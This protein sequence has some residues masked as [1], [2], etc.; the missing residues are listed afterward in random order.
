MSSRFFFVFKQ[1]FQFRYTFWKSESVRFNS[2]DAP[3]A[4]ARVQ[5]FQRLM[6][7]GI[8]EGTVL[9]FVRL[10]L[11][12]PG[13]LA[14]AFVRLS[15]LP[16]VADGTIIEVRRVVLLFSSTAPFSE[17]VACITFFRRPAHSAFRHDPCARSS[18][19]IQSPVHIV[20]RIVLPPVSI[21][22]PFRE[23]FTGCCSCF[24]CDF[25]VAGWSRVRLYHCWSYL[26]W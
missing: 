23:R 1:Y 3:S 13:P 7:D 16:T 9:A 12:V 24:I 25:F 21:R 17:V 2:Q 14:E 11:Q 8:V 15:R 26:A 18:F 4:S 10:V 19:V 5:Y 6:H 22:L 20:Q